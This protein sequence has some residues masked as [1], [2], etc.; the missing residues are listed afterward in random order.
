MTNAIKDT[1]HPPGQVVNKVEA[2]QQLS[3]YIRSIK[4]RD[5]FD[6]VA[7]ENKLSFEQWWRQY[8]AEHGL[9][10]AYIVAGH[11]WAAGQSNK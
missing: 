10:P 2:H 6:Q 9:P 5:A 11:A 1:I 7:K 3:N 8:N 4:R